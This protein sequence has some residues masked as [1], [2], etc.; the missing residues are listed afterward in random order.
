MKT[1]SRW[2]GI[3]LIVSVFLVAACSKADSNK[4]L[5]S[6]DSL[7]QD[8]KATLSQ[9]DSVMAQKIALANH[10]FGSETQ[11]RELLG[12]VQ[13]AH[14]AVTTSCFVDDKGVLRYLEP[15]EYK[16]SEG[17][18][19]SQQEHNQAMLA[20]PQPTLSTAF[21]AVEGLAV[22]TLARPLFNGDD[23]FVGSLVLTID[24]SI[25]AQ[26][27]L[28][29]NA[30]PPEYELWAMEPSGMIVCDQDPE[31]IGKNI[32][33][34]PIYDSYASLKELARTIA[35]SSSGEGRYRFVATGTKRE[36]E[37]NATWSSFDYYG[38]TWRV[39]LVKVS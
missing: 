22:V 15:S 36:V 1:Y 6:A 5:F 14:E 18:D 21:M 2:I 11:I 13:S 28:T 39:I 3:A 34:D 7:A 19:V 23:Q 32:F 30:I 35:G 17:A 16:S 25:L 12:A 9:I 27:V 38:R 26:R 4:D 33:T 24:P 8:L 29:L 10:Q 31:E 37:K 20:N